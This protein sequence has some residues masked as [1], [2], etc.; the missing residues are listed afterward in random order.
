MTT[1]ISDT[2]KDALAAEG[3]GAALTAGTLWTLYQGGALSPA[4]LA[5]TATTVGATAAL[6]CSIG[7]K[8][9]PMMLGKKASNER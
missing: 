7:N 2:I 9:A 1:E 8:L 3:V 4:A 5:A 6:A